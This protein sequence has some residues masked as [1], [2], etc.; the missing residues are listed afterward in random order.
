MA[1]RIF[2][3]ILTDFL[4]WFPISLLGIAALAGARIPP[5]VYAWVAVFILPLNSALNP[6]LYTVSTRAFVAHAQKGVRRFRSFRSSQ[7]RTGST[8]FSLRG[9]CYMLIDSF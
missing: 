4:C 5:Q 6:L 9:T 3:I 7:L 8:R 2:L 1:R